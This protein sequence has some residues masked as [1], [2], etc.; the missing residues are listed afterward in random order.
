[1]AASEPNVVIS[2]II[3]YLQTFWSPSWQKMDGWDGAYHQR[4]ADL[5]PIADSQGEETVGHEENQSRNLSEKKHVAHMCSD[6]QG[7]GD[8]CHRIAEEMRPE[9]T[10]SQE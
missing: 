6:D 1:M 2:F 9:A 7:F 5:L 10:R 8:A 4:L 3:G